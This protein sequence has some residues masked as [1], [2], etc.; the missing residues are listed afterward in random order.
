MN[1]TFL[2]KNKKKGASL[3]WLQYMLKSNLTRGN[4]VHSRHDG[5]FTLFYMFSDDL[6]PIQ[7]LADR[8]VYV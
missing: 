5:Y 6:A 8:V 3:C 4:I 2:T 1:G 7:H